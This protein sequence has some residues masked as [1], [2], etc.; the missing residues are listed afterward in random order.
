MCWH[1]QPM[2]FAIVIL[3]LFSIFLGTNAQEKIDL[4]DPRQNLDSFIKTRASLDGSQVVFWWTGSIYSFIEGERSQHLFNFEGY[5]IA[6]A[7]KVEQGYLLLT[8]EASF[9]KDPQSGEILEQWKNPFTGTT[10]AVIQVWNDPANQ[11]LFLDVTHGKFHIPFA[12]LGDDVYWHLEIFL[13]Y[14]SPL[15]REQYPL[16][17]QSNEYQAGELFQ[18]YTKR[19]QLEDATLPSVPCQISWTRIS[20]W[21]PW[22]EMGNRAGY[23]V[24]HCSGKKL[25]DGFQELPES[26]KSYVE[27]HQ[28]EFQTAP[29][30]FTEPNETSW[31]YF[32]K[33]L[34][35]RTQKLNSSQKQHH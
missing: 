2:G 33:L 24:Y 30:E 26:I 9:Y 17:S 3:S 7:K 20:P 31:T 21:L 10:V 34:E 16:Y 14:P 13:K 27:K 5:N 4:S 29:D 23:L 32:K 18:Y 12:E 8:R 11:K 35:Q 6:K 22:M 28:P 19:S 1:V 15:P 25:S